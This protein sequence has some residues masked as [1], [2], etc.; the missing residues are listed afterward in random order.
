VQRDAPLTRRLVQKWVHRRGLASLEAFRRSTLPTV[1]GEVA[2]RWL[3]ELMEAAD[4]GAAQPGPIIDAALESPPPQEVD[5]AFAALAAEFS[6]SAAELAASAAP[7]PVQPA[8]PPPPPP[9]AT[10]MPLSTAIAADSIP[11][12]DPIEP[13]AADQ[14]DESA[15]ST[16]RSFSGPARLPG[17]GRLKRLLR[18]CYAGAIG[19]GS[20]APEDPFAGV[21]PSG[22]PPSA[23]PL[24]PSETPELSFEPAFA[25]GADQ[26]SEPAAPQDAEPAWSEPVAPL[27]AFH[28]P[29]AGG[30]DEHDSIMQSVGPGAPPPG[31]AFADQAGEGRQM[32]RNPLTFRLPR[33]GAPS[34]S[35]RPAPAPDALAELRAWLPDQDNDLPRAC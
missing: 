30:R 32:M 16:E 15:G 22:V 5:A 11:L 13:C 20:L 24:V 34:S 26:P 3:E 19:N 35:Q 8:P 17:L 18:G 31:G 2:C 10:A 29:P 21:P 33:L 12:A 14:Q 27:P 4:N 6:V 7:P 28:T 9:V 23:S 25:R 1:A